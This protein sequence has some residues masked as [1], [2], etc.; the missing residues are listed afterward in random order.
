MDAAL[1][2]MVSNG[3]IPY[4]VAALGNSAGPIWSGAAGERASGMA[5]GG[6]TIFRIVSMSKAVGA[7]AALILAD[8]GRLNWETP[9]EEILPEFARLV[10]IE[11]GVET[12]LRRPAR[13]K[14]TL[15]NLATHTSG[16]AYEFWDGAVGRYLAESGMPSIVSGQRAGLLYPLA[17]DP[18]TAWQY[19]GGADWLGLA[20]S[21]IDGRSIDRF[22]IEEI[23]EP[24][25]LT[26]T[27]FELNATSAALL[28][29]VLARTENGE[30][31]S[32]VLNLDPPA[33]PEFYGMGHALNSTAPDYLRF[34]RMWLGMGS[35]D[36]V[37][38]LSEATA[39]DA[40]RNQIGTL[41]IEPR[42]TVFAPATSDLDPMP[43]VELSHSLVAARTERQVPGRRAVGSAFWGGVL[44]THFWLDPTADLAGVFMTQV[45]PFLDGYVMRDLEEFERLS[46]SLMI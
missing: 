20:V 10:V 3:S 25:G 14:A 27:S 11:N 45:V 42:S 34:L 29:D 26:S 31:G 9:V 30:L 37:R 40:L 13:T 44:N 46:Y 19:G 17:F 16:L 28:G 1:D 15:R 33:S 6:D 7:T 18:G 39:R 35:L 22:C 8:R 23:F 36:G 5:A 4:V 32:S 24:L 2:A 43:G 21:A 12:Q 38:I 41:R